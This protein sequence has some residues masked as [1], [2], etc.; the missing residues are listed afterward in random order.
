MEG[1]MDK[2]KKF[3]NPPLF[4]NNSPSNQQDQSTKNKHKIADYFGKMPMQYHVQCWGCDQNHLYKGFTSQR[5][6]NV[7][8]M[9]VGGIPPISNGSFW[10]FSSLTV[11]VY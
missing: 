3:V 6:N 4:K 11:F 10:Q 5:R 7:I 1:N 9:D 2:R 8:H